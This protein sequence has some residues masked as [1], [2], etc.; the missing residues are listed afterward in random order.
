M[1]CANKHCDQEAVIAAHVSSSG[2]TI[3][4]RTDHLRVPFADD[5]RCSDCAVHEL[6]SLLVSALPS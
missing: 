3:L 4:F 2:A 5:A 1:K 6:L